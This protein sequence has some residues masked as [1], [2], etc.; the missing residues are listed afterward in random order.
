MVLRLARAAASAGF[1]LQALEVQWGDAG[2]GVLRQ[3][4]VPDCNEACGLMEG[5]GLE[6]GDVDDAEDRRV[7]ADAEGEREYDDSGEARRAAKCA[8]HLAKL[9][10]K[11]AHGCFPMI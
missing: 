9:L 4:G 11:I 2:L 8:E 3:V 6:Q 10:R 7:R 5:Q 1:A